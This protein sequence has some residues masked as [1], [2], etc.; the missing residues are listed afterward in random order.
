MVPTTTATFGQMAVQVQTSQYGE[1]P[2]T[3][4]FSA[5]LR[6]SEEEMVGALFRCAEVGLTADELD[7]LEYVRECV[8][9]QVINAGLDEINEAC[10]RMANLTPD[11]EW[12]DFVPELRTAVRRAFALDIPV[13]RKP[14]RRRRDLAEVA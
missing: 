14:V 2:R 13:P 12:A 8:A 7:D 9:G 3:T 5:P 10:A 1:Q 11:S 4:A 6:L